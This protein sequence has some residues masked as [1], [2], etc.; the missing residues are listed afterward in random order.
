M[1]Q[2][3]LEITNKENYLLIE[4]PEGINFFEIMKGIVTLFTMS[5]Y[6]EN[7]DIWIF[8][9]GHPDLLYSDLHEIKRFADKH[10]PEVPHNPKISHCY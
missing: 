2:N 6:Q 5:A 10:Y 3:G 1:R 9:K 8:R 4:P 7:G